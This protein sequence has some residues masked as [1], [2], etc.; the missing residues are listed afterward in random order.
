M[1]SNSSSTSNSD[2]NPCIID[3]V[4]VANECLICYLVLKE[5]NTFQC[6]NCKTK[7]CVKCVKTYLL[8]SSQEPHCPNCRTAMDYDTFIDKFDKT[9]RLG[10]YKTHK[11]KILWDL[12]QAQFPATV[13]YLNLV[14]KS[15]ELHDLNT[16]S[17]NKYANYIVEIRKINNM[18]EAETK[19]NKSHS[20]NYKEVLKNLK[21][22]RDDAHEKWQDIRIQLNE[23]Q[24]QINDFLYKKK[25]IKYEWSQPCPTGDCK[26]F[27]NDKHECIICNKKY[28]KHCLENVTDVKKEDHKCNEELVETIKTIRKESRPCPKCGEFISKIS[29]CDQMFCTGCGTAFS[30]VT[31]QVEQGII[32]NPHAHHFFRT[33]PKAYEEYMNRRNGVQTGDNNEGMGNCR[34]VLPTY[35]R[36]DQIIDNIEI[37]ELKKDCENINENIYNTVSTRIGTNITILEKIRTMFFNLAEYNQYGLRYAE[38]SVNGNIDTLQLRIEYI[39]N[40]LTEKKYKSI[41]HM[42]HKKT[43]F[44][45]LIHELIRSTLIICG[46]LLWNITQV[47]NSDDLDK[48]YNMINEIRNNTNQC[49]VNLQNKHNYKGKM[50]IEEYMGI[51]R[52]WV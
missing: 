11:E 18:K 48:Y 31:G 42:R 30:W 43:S 39:N 6:F 16:L 38:Q 15:S 24:T 10:V 5:K 1:A 35:F 40:R 46:E 34:P 29:G 20:M 13:G 44:K 23:V 45:K 52:Y 25:N 14:K 4:E 51:P 28:C 22:A 33:N 9:W 26:G 17:Y 2:I 19:L 8:S 12:E 41:L 47:N 21:K 32:H 50:Q 37:N 27:L 49:I 36:I 3:N 7:C